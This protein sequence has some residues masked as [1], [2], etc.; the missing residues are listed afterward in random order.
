MCSDCILH[1]NPSSCDCTILPILDCELLVGPDLVLFCHHV[2]V[3]HIGTLSGCNE[4][5]IECVDLV[6][7]SL[8]WD[9]CH[10]DT[11]VLDWMSQR[12]G[13]ELGRPGSDGGLC[14][15]PPFSP[16]TAAEN[17]PLQGPL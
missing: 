1:C 13:L 15:L 4:C 2:G 9:P 3:E 16:L 8:Y 14:L 12:V 11:L 10:P 17:S 7:S 5:G 6:Q